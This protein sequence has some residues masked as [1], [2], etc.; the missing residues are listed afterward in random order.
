MAHIRRHLV[1][2]LAIC[3]FVPACED[4]SGS[5]VLRLR[6]LLTEG[7]Q[8]EVREAALELSL[9]PPRTVVERLPLARL[10]IDVDLARRAV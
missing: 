4:E 9:D 8:A 3:T 7:R 10:L 6:A 2:L 5:E 1:L